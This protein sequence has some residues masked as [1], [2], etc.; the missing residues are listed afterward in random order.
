[1]QYTDI[2]DSCWDPIRQLA[3]YIPD[4]FGVALPVLLSAEEVHV[5]NGYSLAEMW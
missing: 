4:H 1:M 5:P 3:S 2:Y